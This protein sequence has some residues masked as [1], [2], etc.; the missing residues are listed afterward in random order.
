MGKAQN[1]Q[2]VNIMKHI[3]FEWERVHEKECMKEC[4]KRAWNVQKK[5]LKRSPKVVKTV[6]LSP[7]IKKKSQTNGNMSAEELKLIKKY[8]GAD[9]IPVAVQEVPDDELYKPI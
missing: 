8:E 1:A 2:L 7:K 4:M 9:A 5:V 3:H 6:T